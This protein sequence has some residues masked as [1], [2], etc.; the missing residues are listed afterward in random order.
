M[1]FAP[2]LRWQMMAAEILSRKLPWL[3]VSSS[4]LQ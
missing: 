2:A 3:K 1:F 4:N